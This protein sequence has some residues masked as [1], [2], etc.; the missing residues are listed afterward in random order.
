MI[1]SKVTA[2]LLNR[3]IL[4][5]SSLRR[6][7]ASWGK[8]WRWQMSRLGARVLHSLQERR[9]KNF[10]F[11]RMVRESENNLKHLKS[12]SAPAGIFF[13]SHSSFDISRVACSRLV[14]DYVLILQI[15]LYKDVFLS[16]NK[17]YSTKSK[18]ILKFCLTCHFS[19]S[20]LDII[21]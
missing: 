12:S 18:C 9:K 15:F 11:H 19:G 13:S 20:Q 17:M 5:A 10:P 21:N 6:H 3:W 1:G 8:L 2:I 7:P 14:L 16:P 4:P